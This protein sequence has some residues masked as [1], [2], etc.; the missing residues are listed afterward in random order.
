M[1]EEGTYDY[2]EIGKPYV[3]GAQVGSEN[4]KSYCPYCGEKEL[5]GEDS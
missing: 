2:T 4:N 1:T 3:W 5:W